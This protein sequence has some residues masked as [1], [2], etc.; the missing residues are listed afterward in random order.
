MRDP[1]RE[2]AAGHRVWPLYVGGFLGPYGSTMVTPMVHEVAAGLDSTPQTAAAAVSAYMLPFAALMLVS[3]TLAERWG[4]GG[5]CVRR[6][7][8]SWWR[9]RCAPR[10]RPWN[11]S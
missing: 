6:W 3:G 5:Y 10:L 8:R 2:R 1:H 11:S 9:P 4:A 7:R